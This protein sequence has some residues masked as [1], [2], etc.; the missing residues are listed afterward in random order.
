MISSRQIP[1]IIDSDNYSLQSNE[2]IIS[3]LLFDSRQLINASQ[4]L[5]FAIITDN[6]NGHDYIETL[7]HQGVRNFV[8]TEN[9][10]RFHPLKANFFQVSNAVLALQQIAAFHR[11]QFNIP[12]VAITGSN[13]KTI[14]KEW[15]T[16]ILS[17]NFSVIANPNSYNSQI[18]VPI[19]VWQMKKNHN[20]AVFEAG[21]SCRG[22]MENLEKIIQPNVGILTNIGTA[23]NLFF[24][25]DTEKLQEKLKLFA[26]SEKIIYCCDNKLIEDELKNERYNHLI[27]ISWGQSENAHYRIEEKSVT[28]YATLVKF[29]DE[30]LFLTIPFTD[31]A[32]VENLLHISIFLRDL[33]FSVAQINDMIYT[34]SPI[35]GRMEIKEAIHHSIVLNDTYS[36]DLNSLRIALSFLNVQIHLKKKTLIISDFSQVCMQDK[37][38]EILANTISKNNISKLVLVGPELQKRA[39]IF[40]V[41]EQ[42]CYKSTQELID[43][44]DHISISDEAVLVKG[45]RNFKFEKI[46]EILQKKRQQTILQVNLEAII[47]NLNYFKSKLKPSTKMTAMVKAMCYGLGDAELISELIYHHIDYLAVAYTDEGILLRKRNISAPIIVL[48]AEAANFHVM[49]QHHLEPEIYSLHY[50]KQL[51]ENLQLFPDIKAY[52][53]H[54]K[55]DTGMHRLGFDEKDIDEVIDLVAKNPQIRIASV[56]SHLAAAED[57]NE[58]DF[59]KNQI[60][61]FERVCQKI[62]SKISTPFIRH[63]LNSSGIIYYPES[64][65]DMV[66]LGIGLYGFNDNVE[67]QKHLQH[68]ITLKSVIT[69]VKTIKAGETIGYN[70]SYKTQKD[71][72]IAVVPIGYADGLPR[73]LSNGVGE[74]IVQH[75]RCP[76]VGKICMDM[77]MIDVTGL[78]IKEEEEVI[79]YGE[80]NRVD[81]IAKSI[82]KIPYELLTSI[83][84]RVPRTYLRD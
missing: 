64:Q 58:Q 69:Q 13:G 80:E 74:M 44:L 40:H 14:V 11:K 45:A 52:P 1:H 32:S 70:R 66:R 25:N 15:L 49:I 26:N 63:I 61:I 34:L 46:V 19:S 21:I 78:P 48:G 3:E 68:P 83:S 50:L 31:D 17:I 60:C 75:H 56:F 71:M 12:V 72:Q 41:D 7:Y 38:Y 79:I 82:H 22:E 8:I 53:I 9:L 55:I 35:A 84:R 28:N 81:T 65:Y 33:G 59:T 20:F 6:G 77:C 47:H 36:L 43:N 76:I 18:G 10:S 29:C 27:K 57:V 2:T 24:Q 23:H 4:T 51:E 39:A 67:V 54:L 5:F 16:Q 37:D 62:A 73:E 42:F 30:K